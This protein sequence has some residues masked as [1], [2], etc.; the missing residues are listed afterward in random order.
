M[1]FKNPTI[2]ASSWLLFTMYSTVKPSQYNLKK[3]LTFKI[4]NRLTKNNLPKIF[5]V[6]KN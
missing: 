5:I 4:N 3:N 1:Y 6:T 2:Y